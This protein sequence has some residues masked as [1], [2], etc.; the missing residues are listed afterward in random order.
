MYRDLLQ[1][2]LAPTLRDLRRNPDDVENTYW[3][4]PFREFFV[5]LSMA[6]ANDHTDNEE[7]YDDSDS[8]MTGSSHENQPEINVE[9]ALNAFVNMY[10]PSRHRVS[11]L[12]LQ[13]YNYLIQK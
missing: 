3:S 1:E 9:L 10:P 8:H 11:F 12:L 7:E 2:V 5:Q 6:I 13:T 4:N